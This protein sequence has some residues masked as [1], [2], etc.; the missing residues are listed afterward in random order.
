MLVLLLQ[1]N[2]LLKVRY[3][4]QLGRQAGNK[5]LGNSDVEHPD[6]ENLPDHV[7]STRWVTQLLPL[8]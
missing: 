7:V 2:S 3:F 6:P 8:A 5:E 1:V 4:T